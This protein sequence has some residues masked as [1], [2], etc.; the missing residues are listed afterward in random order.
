MSIDKC[1]YCP[2]EGPPEQV[3]KHLRE[4]HADKI[5]IIPNKR[6]GGYVIECPPAPEDRKN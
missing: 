6:T 2:W 1:P 5:K 3:E 4:N